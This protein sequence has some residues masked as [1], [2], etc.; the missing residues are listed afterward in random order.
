MDNMQIMEQRVRVRNLIRAGDTEAA[1]REAE[2]ALRSA[3]GDVD[4][5][6]IIGGILEVC[7]R[8]NDTIVLARLIAHASE[9]L[10][11]RWKD[12]ELTHADLLLGAACRSGSLDSVRLIVEV[13]GARVD[14]T[15][16][17]G[18]EQ[19][20]LSCACNSGNAE[21]ARYLLERGAN[22]NEYRPKA[23][24]FPLLLAAHAGNLPLVKVLVEHGAA[25]NGLNP[26]G[27][28]PLSYALMKN[29]LDTVAYLRSVG[30]LEPW[31][32]RGEAGP[33]APKPKPK[34]R[35]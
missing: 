8:I 33:P 1:I 3:E 20:P 35:K 19:I 24:S 18:E 34:K 25:V 16:S 14:Y 23:V 12:T 29:D 22:P 13:G 28:S 15:S 17:N 11:K 9:N 5:D 26:F 6:I 7:A 10:Q 21:L 4:A 32:I 27:L 31:Q 30:A 2:A